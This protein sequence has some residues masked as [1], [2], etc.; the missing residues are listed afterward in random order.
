MAISI[1]DLTFA[2]AVM[3]AVS[4]IA[5]GAGAGPAVSGLAMPAI[6]GAGNFDRQ[7]L[8]RSPIEAID[9]QSPPIAKEAELVAAPG[10]P[11]YADGRRE[12]TDRGLL[13]GTDAEKQEK[14][15]TLF[16]ASIRRSMRSATR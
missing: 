9:A 5:A 3:A 12:E 7:R 8:E 16:A 2:V 11:P 4:F 1:R 14:A 13:V 10:G 6:E 15:K